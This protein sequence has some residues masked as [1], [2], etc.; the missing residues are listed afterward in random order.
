[1]EKRSLGKS[2]IMV[3]PLGMGCWAIGGQS[4]NQ[5]G[6]AIG[7]TG[8]DDNE[9]IRAIH[10]AI[11]LG[12]NFFDT[13]N[14]YGSG[15]SEEVLGKALASRRGEVVI[16]TKFGGTFDSE[17]RLHLG[18]DPSVGNMR[19]SLDESLRRLQTDTIDLYQ[20]HIWGHPA[21]QAVELR[22][23][24][25]EEVKAGK[26][27][28]Y[29]WSTDVLE[30]Q[31]VFA[32]GPNCIAVQ[33]ELHAL[34][35]HSTG[36]TDAILELCEEKDMASLNRSPLAMG[37]LTGKFK[38]GM[39]FPEGDVRRQVEWFGAFKDGQPNPDWLDMLDSIKEVLT[40]GGRTM[41]QGAL[42][43]I[44]AYSDRTIPIPGF[45]N[46]KQAEDNAGAMDFGPLTPD[47]MAQIDQILGR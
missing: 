40:S 21:D 10:R 43:W 32:E 9:S 13:A 44:W 28:G 19:R 18:D 31:K 35:K 2:G 25:E 4:Y 46:T 45:K 38:R 20:F 33:Q 5:E 16:A 24:L 37:L 14:V 42:A 1:M 36:D 23:A 22:E 7:W 15:H 8:I 17:K 12:V 26:I 30:S 39:T 47:Q 34:G 41:A 27:R 29:G 3:S 6:V 11:D